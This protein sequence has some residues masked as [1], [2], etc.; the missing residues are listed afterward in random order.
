MV[1]KPAKCLPRSLASEWYERANDCL[2]RARAYETQAA[3]LH[4]RFGVDIAWLLRMARRERQAA[5][6][7]ET[8]ADAASLGSDYEDVGEL[9]FG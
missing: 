4:E 5:K 9:P 8:Q 3:E 6:K 7:F 2:R 1:N